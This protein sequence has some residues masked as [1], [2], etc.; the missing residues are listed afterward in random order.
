MENE[1]PNMYEVK[2]DYKGA[3]FGSLAAC[4]HY[5]FGSTE[6]GGEECGY[7]KCKTKHPS[8]RLRDLPQSLHDRWCT[9]AASLYATIYDE[10]ERPGTNNETVVCVMHWM[11]HNVID[12]EQ[13]PS[14]SADFEAMTEEVQDR[15]I[16]VAAGIV[17]HI[18]ND[19]ITASDRGVAS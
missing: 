4:L 14:S 9:K 15:W 10:V 12:A 11:L 16:M 8:T 5:N 1:N 13:A 19:V 6:D 17:H 18:N 3:L 7:E 2:D